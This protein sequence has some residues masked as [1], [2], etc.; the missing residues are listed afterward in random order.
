MPLTRFSTTSARVEPREREGVKSHTLALIEL[1]QG[2]DCGP[3]A[4]GNFGHW[5]QVLSFHLGHELSS[6]LRANPI[7]VSGNVFDPGHAHRGF[8]ASLSVWTTLSTWT[9]E[10]VV[11]MGTTLSGR[12]RQRSRVAGRRTRLV[13]RGSGRFNH[14]ALG[15]PS[16]CLWRQT[17][18][19][20]SGQWPGRRAPSCRFHGTARTAIARERGAS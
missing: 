10:E 6:G 8:V 3:E 16:L 1:M 13:C 9:V 17:R 14:W 5:H 2:A 18:G 7:Q 19:P 20:G 12:T 4:V 11:P 15:G